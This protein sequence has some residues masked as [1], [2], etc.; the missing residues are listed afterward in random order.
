LIQQVAAGKV[1]K[2]IAPMADAEILV[3]VENLTRRFPRCEALGGVSFRICRGEIAGF[4]GP[5]G[6]GKTTTLRILAGYLAPTSGR[7]QVAGFDVTT[8]SLEVRRRIGYLPEAV[9]LYPEMRVDEYL[10]FRGRIRGL[11]G[12]RLSTRLREV[13]EQCGLGEVSTRIIGNLSRGFRQRTGLADCLLHEPEVL[14]L[15]EPLAGLDP[16]QVQLTR[17]LL[18]AAGGSR[19]V[20]FSTHV[21]AEAEQLCH[22]ALILNAGRLAAS[23][24]PAR[25]VRDAARLYAELLA[26]SDL[27]TEAIESLT[28]S[29]DARFDPLPD[30]W[31]SVSIRTGEVDLRP[32]LADL[33]QSRQWPLRELRRDARG[34]EEMFLRLTARPAMVQN[35]G[36]RKAR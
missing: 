1:S 20:L 10:S 12:T 17:E 3:E 31:T 13:V 24:S 29:A 27:L 30:G 14:L 16:A 23:D 34:F 5:N 32:Q 7:V 18:R 11:H 6:S 4:L 26:P 25:L 36:K 33:A 8:H 28:S 21:L 22:R 15:D 9:P 2:G 35:P 19:A